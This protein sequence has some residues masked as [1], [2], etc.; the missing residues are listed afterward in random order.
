RPW[1]GSPGTRVEV[2]H[3]FYETPV[4]RKF[5]RTT[6]TEV[7]HVCEAVTRLALAYPTLHLVLRHN[8]KLV[9]DVPATAS[10]L[11]RIGLFFGRAVTEGLYELDAAQGPAH[12]GAYVA[13][14]ACQ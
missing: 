5:L 11:D 7:G 4:R 10:L 9:H 2:R 3:L 13:H 1:N 14:P 8:G 12:L 6:A